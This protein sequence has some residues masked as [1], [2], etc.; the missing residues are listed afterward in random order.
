MSLQTTKQ[1]CIKNCSDYWW[2]VEDFHLEAGGEGITLT[3]WESQKVDTEV[4][5]TYICLD[6]EA[7]MALADAIRELADPQAIPFFEEHP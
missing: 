6:L 4:R 7:A 2:T 5:K 1:I 3:L